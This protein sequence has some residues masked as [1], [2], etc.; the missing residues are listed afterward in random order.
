MTASPLTAHVAAPTDPTLPARPSSWAAAVQI[1]RVLADRTVAERSAWAL[2]V[3]AL[4][5][6]SALTLSVAGGVRWFYAIG[7][8]YGP[9]YQGLSSIALVLLVIPLAT[10]AG[11]A[12]RLAVSR[13][14][15]RLSSLRLLGATTTTVRALTLLETGAIALL[16]AVVGVAGYLALMPAFGLLHFTGGPIGPTGLWLGAGP[17]LL[18]V[19]GIVLLTLVSAAI[20]LRRVVISPLG[21]R[22]RQTAPRLHW[23]RVL[24]GGVAI[25][26]SV[27]VAENIGFL[28]EDIAT[29]IVYVGLALA[30]PLLALNLIGPW[31]IGLIARFDAFRARTP[32]ALIAARTVL[33]NPKVVWRQVGGLSMISFVAVITG[34]S[35]SY[36]ASPASNPGEVLLIAD[37]RTGSLLTLGIAFLTVACSVGITQTAAILDRRS[38]HVGLDML[39]MPVGLID[40]AR[41]RA[42]MRPLVLVVVGSALPGLLLVLP[43]AGFSQ[44]SSIETLVVTPL[45]LVAGVALVAASLRVTRLTLTGVVAE[46]LARA[47]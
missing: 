17:L 45:L 21:V 3:T 12:A 43:L 14:D 34:V 6:V 9:L 10:L 47:E 30:V 38:L 23:A 37:L 32:D 15:T 25:V 8:E 2:P 16:G 24:V 33:D 27:G 11:A 31:V 35:F 13:R 44:V 42:V 22:T 26:A 39:G 28:A 41:R 20:G 40:K 5:L 36:N 7:G 1:A 19:L 4:A 46:G 18:A 29:A